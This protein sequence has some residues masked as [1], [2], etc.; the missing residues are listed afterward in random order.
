MINYGVIV[1]AIM[2][3]AV[4]LTAI[5]VCYR[6]RKDER[7]KFIEGSK[8]KWVEPNGDEPSIPNKEWL[9]RQCY[10]CFHGLQKE[11]MGKGLSI[12]DVEFKELRQGF[13]EF[14]FH[15][16]ELPGWLF[17]LW[18]SWG[19][20]DEN[21]KKMDC[22]FFWQYGDNCD[23]FKLPRSIHFHRF[24]FDCK[25]GEIDCMP[26]VLEWDLAFMKKEPCLAF[27][28]DV[29]GWDYNRE[30]H[31]RAEAKKACKQIM[32]GFRREKTWAPRLSLAYA[33]K[34]AEAARKAYP[35]KDVSIESQP[36]CSERFS[37]VVSG[38]DV[39]D[40]CELIKNIPNRAFLKALRWKKRREAIIKRLFKTPFDYFGYTSS[41]IVFRKGKAPY[42]W[43][44]LG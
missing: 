2:S 16:N 30:Y 8:I 10:L 3:I 44:T 15:V 33:E 1:S 13:G 26:Y 11:L 23:N 20:D 19:R 25:K 29:L 7:L 24:G 37:V 5:A 34:I 42:D 38:K 31:S 9:E 36:F 43:K 21:P 41:T 32:R 28:R 14:E 17:G 18:I 6:Q 40:G 12:K 35:G 39:K 22:E 4:A 27:C